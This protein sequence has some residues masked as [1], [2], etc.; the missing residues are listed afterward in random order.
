LLSGTLENLNTNAIFENVDITNYDLL[1]N[2]INNYENIDGIFHF[3]AIARTP[4]CI[5]NPIL[6]YNTNVTGTLHILEIARKKKY[7]KNCF[8]FI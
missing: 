4:W 1:R 5:E 6:C 2:V 8:V 7:K 3:A